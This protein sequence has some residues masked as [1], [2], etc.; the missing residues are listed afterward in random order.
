MDNAVIAD[1]VIAAV[2]LTGVLIGVQRGL[3]KSLMG[4]LSAAAALIGAALLANLLAPAV[5]ELVYPRVRELAY[6]ALSVARNAELHGF[7]APQA[8]ERLTEALGR[9]G[10]TLEDFDLTQSLAALA[11]QASRTLIEGVVHTLLFVVLYLVILL[12]LRLATATLDHVFDLPLL[13]TLNGA[14]GGALGLGEAALLLYVVLYAL[15][16]FGV[17]LVTTLAERAVLLR[18]FLDHTPVELLSSFARKG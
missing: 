14:L 3:F 17:E 15:R 12:A 4:F 6:H 16:H 8:M 11:E 18:F 2:L 7:E 9:F 5:A 13:N 10:I 1:L